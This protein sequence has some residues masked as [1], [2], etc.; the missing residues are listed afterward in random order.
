[1]SW[2]Y[3]LTVGDKRETVRLEVTDSYRGVISCFGRLPLCVEE[4]GVGVEVND[5]Y[6]VCPYENKSLVIDE[7]PR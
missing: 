3:P 5:N 2:Y 1:M 4:E 7:A 6:Q